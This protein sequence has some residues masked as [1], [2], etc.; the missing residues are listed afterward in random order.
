MFCLA[1]LMATLSVAAQSKTGAY[2][3][4]DAGWTVPGGSTGFIGEVAGGVRHGRWGWGL[5]TGMDQAA[6]KSIPLLVDVR[7]KI[8]P[9]VHAL[10]IFSQE[11]LN[12][13]NKKIGWD[14]QT[15]QDGVYWHGGLT[16]RVIDTR[17]FGGL[18]VSAGCRYRTY[19]ESTPLA[20]PFGGTTVDI[21]PAGPGFNGPTAMVNRHDDWTGVVTIGWRW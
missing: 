7:W 11:G 1:C 3:M 12:D 8:I 9:G 19:K 14:G 18:W 10:E 15:Y 13:V 20:V 2:G 17:G 16:W 21:L 5:A 6:V 4:V